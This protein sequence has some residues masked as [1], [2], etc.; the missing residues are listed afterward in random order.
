[1]SISK[2]SRLER[3]V[4]NF[5]KHLVILGANGPF[6]SCVEPYYESEA[7]CKVFVM[8][9]SFHSFICKQN[10]FSYETFCT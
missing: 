4:D 10:L 2:R 3:R 9:T 1:M 6:P 8:K 5:S 7:K